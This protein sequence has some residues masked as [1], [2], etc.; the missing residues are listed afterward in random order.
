[1]RLRL[2]DLSF[3]AIGARLG[4]KEATVRQRLSRVL[5]TLA[6]LPCTPAG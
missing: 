4:L 3:A 6:E 2:D 5:R 1:V